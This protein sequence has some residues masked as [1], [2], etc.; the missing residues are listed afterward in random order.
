MTS[1]FCSLPEVPEA[2]VRQVRRLL[3]RW[4]GARTVGRSDAERNLVR[5][6]FCERASSEK[7]ET[8]VARVQDEEDDALVVLG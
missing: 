6:E 7:V 1:S 8:R 2:S 3:T 5:E 4:S